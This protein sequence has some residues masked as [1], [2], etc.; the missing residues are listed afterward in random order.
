M[1]SQAIYINQKL[2]NIENV[3]DFVNVALG[4][5]TPD[6]DTKTKENYARLYDEFARTAAQEGDE[7]TFREENEFIN[8]LNKFLGLV[9]HFR[10]NPF[11]PKVFFPCDR[12]IAQ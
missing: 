6:L 5:D 12:I 1:L 4:K 11:C 7:A 10:S 3:E 8:K 9:F 2:G